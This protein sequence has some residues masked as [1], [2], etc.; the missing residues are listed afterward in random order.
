MLRDWKAE[1]LRRGPNAGHRGEP[2]LSV[3]F[4][5]TRR[6]TLADKYAR[7]A[8]IHDELGEKVRRINPWRMSRANRE[9][10]SNLTRRDN[11]MAA[12]LSLCRQVTQKDLITDDRESDV[13]AVLEE[14]TVDLKTSLGP[15]V[16]PVR[17]KT[18]P[19][20]AATLR[21]LAGMLAPKTATQSADAKPVADSPKSEQATFS[22]DYSTGWWRGT[23][24]HFLGEQQRKV[25]R[26]L[27]GAYPGTVAIA[28]L[29][30]K[31]K[32]TEAFRVQT[33]FRKHPALG[34]LIVSPGKG[35]WRLAD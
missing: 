22:R 20:D 24:F 19:T 13:F 32:S 4:F 1:T 7:L 31:M 12:Y 21:T 30:E 11:P 34:T 6:L 16:L 14:V 35:L 29:R 28:T 2:D 33:I 26:V 27:N 17:R 23:E 5:P 10:R 25:V 8:A 18:L 15:R 3:G 9:G